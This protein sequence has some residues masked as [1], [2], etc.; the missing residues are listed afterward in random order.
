MLDT[1][2]STFVRERLKGVS[3]IETPMDARC[4]VCIVIPVYDEPVHRIVNLLVSIARQRDVDP[5]TVEVVCVVN[6]GPSDGSRKWSMAE[7]ANRLI[8]DLPFWRNRD[9]FGGHLRFPSDVLEACAE[10]RSAVPAYVVEMQTSGSGVV[11]EALNRG[12]AEAAVRFDRTGKDGIVIFF[13]ADNVVDDP[14]YV[15][16]AMRMFQKNK[17]LVAVSG[18]V[19]LLFDPDARVESQREIIADLVNRLLRRK[20]MNVLERF[21]QGKDPNLMAS[22]AFLGSNILAR[23]AEAAAWGGFPDWKQHE[24]SEFGYSAK[25]YAKAERKRVFDAKDSLL[26]TSALRDSDRTGSSLKQQLEKEREMEPISVETY[27]KLELQV[28]ATEEGRALIDRI[29]EPANILWDN[30]PN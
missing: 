9:S 21:L 17:D 19:R 3:L 11:G 1:R 30:Y 14:D 24:D 28:G 22:D 15:A 23:S 5:G 10:V 2:A 25:E 13:G 26:I 29:E 12:L 27:E 4:R 7:L 16:N 20:R 8:L 6:D 18:G